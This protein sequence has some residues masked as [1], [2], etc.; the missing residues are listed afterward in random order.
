M[1]VDIIDDADQ[2]VKQQA[3]GRCEKPLW[4]GGQGGMEVHVT[5]AWWGAHESRVY[6]LLVPHTYGRVCLIVGSCERKQG[7]GSKISRVTVL[8]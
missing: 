7:A 5:Q 8:A 6:I 2:S 1:E 4:K 3:N